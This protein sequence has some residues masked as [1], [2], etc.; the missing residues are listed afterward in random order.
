MCLRS[1]NRVVKG[2]FQARIT[3]DGEIDW[4]ET[5]PSCSFDRDDPLRSDALVP[6]HQAVVLCGSEPTVIS[7]RTLPCSSS[8]A[9]EWILVYARADP[10]G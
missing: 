3:R 4:R 9:A 1:I 2:F 5:E 8:A 7:A 10:D 6:S